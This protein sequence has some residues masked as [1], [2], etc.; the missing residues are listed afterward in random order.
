ML[1][2]LHKHSFVSQTLSEL[3]ESLYLALPPTAHPLASNKSFNIDRHLC[4]QGWENTVGT[5]IKQLGRES[6]S[7]PPRVIATFT[8][9]NHSQQRLWTVLRAWAVLCVFWIQLYAHTAVFLFRQYVT[10]HLLLTFYP[11][12]E[13]KKPKG[14]G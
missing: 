13:R 10:S 1:V 12:E 11:Q 14:H 2:R 9:E 3:I 6:W 7:K 8:L 4:L 5:D